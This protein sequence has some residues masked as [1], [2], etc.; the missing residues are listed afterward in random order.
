MGF[1]KSGL[2][3]PPTNI[4]KRI[5]TLPLCGQCGL[6]KGCQSPK[7]DLAGNGKKKILII[8][9][10][11]GKD[12]DREG[13]PFVG[14][15]G[16]YLRDALAELGIDVYEDCWLANSLACRPPGNA[17]P[18]DTQVDCCRPM[19]LKHIATTMPH[20]ILPLGTAAVKSL[21][22]WL[23]K[24]DAGTIMRWAGYQIPNQRLNA[25]ICPVFHP[26]FVMRE[27]GEGRSSE[28]RELVWKQHL[29]AAFENCQ[30]RPWVKVPNHPG[31]IL[32]LHDPDAAVPY[33]D[34]WTHG[35]KP[36]AWDYECE[37]L[38]PDSGLLDIVCCSVSDGTT[39]IAY[40]WHGDAIK[41][42]K[43]LLAS[44]APKIA[45]NLK[46][47]E[48]WTLDRLG[49]PVNN[50]M[51]D[52]MIAAH[53]LDNRPGTTSLKF[54]AFALLGEDSWDGDIK[55]YLKAKGSNE[56]NRIRDIPLTKLLTY[57]ALDSLLEW[58]VAQVQSRQLGVR[59]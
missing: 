26:S 45:S 44:P 59:L 10:A 24:E 5:S 21:L 34:A 42:T 2:I 6:Y 52:T 38:K 43:N 53:V 30:G 27:D 12:E 47:E 4:K 55:P 13:K 1:Y 7:M 22:G 16:R 41:A 15:T 25:W 49:M 8:G 19:L 14:R 3:E 28:V 57:N 33:L 29:A 48:R 56:R 31:E 50:W 39:T 11:P 37:G 20:L 23:W 35:S 17:T 32:V 40:P 46:Y 36:V 58:K 54:Q 18:T 51:W 9:E